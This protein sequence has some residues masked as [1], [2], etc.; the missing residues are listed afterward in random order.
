MTPKTMNTP[1]ENSFMELVGEEYNAAL[2]EHIETTREQRVIGAPHEVASPVSF[3]LGGNAYFTLRSAKTGT[4]FTYRVSLAKTEPGSQ[5]PG[6]TYFVSLLNGPDNWQ[7]YM[8]LGL[9][10]RDCKFRLTKGSKAGADAT[11]VKAFAW[12]WTRLAAGQKTDG[13][14]IWHEG[15]C[16]RCGRKLTVP[17]SIET[18]FGPECATKLEA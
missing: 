10:G 2:A 8:Y 12:T 9:I 7:N 17:E 11:S 15:K 1:F 18:G 4:R 5:Y 14:E 13:V 6:P 16:G 3:I